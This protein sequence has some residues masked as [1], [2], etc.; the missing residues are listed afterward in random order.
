MIARTAKKRCRLR[1][2]YAHEEKVKNRRRKN[3]PAYNNGVHTAD[4]GQ[5]NDVVNRISLGL[6]LSLVLLAAAPGVAQ[7]QTVSPG[8]I[9]AVEGAV[10]DAETGAPV[11]GAV[12]TL[13]D[14][15]GLSAATDAD[16]TFNIPHIPIMGDYQ[17]VTI[18]VAAQNYGVWR[19]QNTVLYPGVTRILSRIELTSETQTIDMGGLPQRG[20]SDTETA[21]QDF[22]ALVP[23]VYD[24]TFFFSHDVIPPTIRVGRTGYLHCSDWLNAKQPILRVEE[25]PFSVYAKN[26]LGNEWIA[27]WNMESLRAG[28]MAVKMFAWYRINLNVDGIR[29]QG[30]HVV[31]NTCDQVYRS[32]SE[33]ST[34]SAAVDDT[35]NHIMRSSG[36]VVGIHYLNT[37]EN[38]QRYFPG[39]RCMGQWGSK[40]LADQGHD[41]QYILHY[42]YDP[43]DITLGTSNI[44]EIPANSNVIQNGT[45][46]DGFSNWFRYGDVGWALYNGV[47]AF[48][49]E[50]DSSDGGIFQIVPYTVGDGST[51]ELVLE[52]GNTSA[53]TKTP[54]VTVRGAVSDVRACQ[55]EIP[56]G[57]PLQPYVI[58]VKTGAWSIPRLQIQ[59][60]PADDQPDVL[61]D[62]VTVFYRP[63]LTIAGTECF[64]VSSDTAWQFDT[65]PAGWTIGSSLD[66]PRSHEAGGVVYDITGDYPLLLSPML[67][68]VDADDYRYVAVK[69][70]S[71][72][73]DCGRIYFQKAGQSS[74]TTMQYVEFPVRTDGGLHTVYADMAS[75]PDW[76]GDITRLRLDARCASSSGGTL[77]VSRIAFT[78]VITTPM[79]L[80]PGLTANE[81]FGDPV[82]SWTPVPGATA[83]QVYI[84]DTANTHVFHRTIS[85]ASICDADRCAFDATVFD[86][87]FRLIDGDYLVAL[88]AWQ[89]TTPGEWAGPFY[90][91][92]SA[93]PPAPP[94]LTATSGLD[95]SRPVFRWSLDSTAAYAL[96]FRLI[97]ISQDNITNILAD[98]WLSR[99]QAC[100][101][102]AQTDCLAQ[103]PT[104][105][106]NGDYALYMQSWGPGGFSAWTGPIRFRV[107]APPPQLPANIRVEVSDGRPVI[108]WDDD[109]YAAW[110]QVVIVSQQGEIA[111]LEWNRRTLSLCDGVTCR[112]LPDVN[113]ANDQYQVYIQ[114]WGAGG[115]SAGGF[116]G[117]AGPAVFDMSYGVPGK[118]TPLTPTGV[119]T[120]QPTF[121]WL[122]A[123][124]A[125]WYQLWVG[126]FVDLE[127]YYLDWH[128]AAL[129]AC[130][131]GVCSLKPD[132]LLPNG[133]Y[134]WYAQAWGP[135]GLGEWAEGGA[136]AVSAG[137][138]PRPS[139]LTPTGVVNDS[140]PTF[141]WQH[142][143]DVLWYEIE[144]GT[145]FD[146]TND[147]HYGWYHAD[148]LLCSMDGVCRLT[149]PDLDFPNG[150]YVW[151]VRAYTPA[152]LGEWSIRQGFTV[153]P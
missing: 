34:T 78:D 70:A 147:A 90:F 13:S 31:D 18:T 108:L 80:T 54:I 98:H 56:P 12:I 133:D 76:E 94:A 30:A 20:Q 81:G 87:T 145:S 85:A 153:S 8:A 59:P 49:R 48:K 35:W 32:N 44:P 125:T 106:P 21:A 136:F 114:A 118:I 135:G 73:D 109:P 146:Q 6:F 60:E 64:G 33:Q 137:L 40:A 91:T 72:A 68:N 17:N 67:Q 69:M 25:M 113:L 95:S 128:D 46:A 129:I 101:S 111:Y 41:W 86:A 37:D 97:V 28:A 38:C 79:L 16:G 29:P 115:F 126:T 107:D 148:T 10:Y 88:R 3:V 1:L 47:L 58:R 112:L 151:R 123:A 93:A 134:V 77:R 24:D 104:D 82:Y 7:A 5:G 124:G 74:F 139:P 71:Q 120:G 122:P 39:A 144:V 51:L 138:P 142:I 65:S 150:S 52:M 89:G 55:F 9:T 14:Y 2:P 96:W 66:N 11:H 102:S 152:G 63:G 100:G 92:L 53:V 143:P 57:A 149:I 50:G 83:Y 75:H 4:V 105:L 132:I 23:Q 42:Y 62:N 99:S 116:E 141:T 117:W 43:V 121:Q 22:A 131:T 15:S 45:F 119:N 110:F 61:L 140:H 26:V 27:T 103:S 127:Q 84:A 36:R 130:A 19:M